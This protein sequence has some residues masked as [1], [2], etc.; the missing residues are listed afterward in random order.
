MSKIVS[1]YGIQQGVQ[2]FKCASCKRVFNGGQRL[3]NHLIWHEYMQGKQTF[4]Q[5]SIKYNCSLKTIQRRL[6][7]VKA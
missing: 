5:V 6:D 1:K 2:R 7:I 4:L 3:I